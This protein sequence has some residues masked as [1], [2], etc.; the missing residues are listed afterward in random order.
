MVIFR[1]ANPFLRNRIESKIERYFG[2]DW[3]LLGITKKSMEFSKNR[4]TKL[5]V[6]LFL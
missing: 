6:V 5:I 4:V 1:V 3:I 2:N